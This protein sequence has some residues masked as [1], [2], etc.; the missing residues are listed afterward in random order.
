MAAGIPAEI[1]AGTTWLQSRMS[2]RC[3]TCW[4]SPPRRLAAQSS[5]RLICGRVYH[6]IP[7]NPEDM[8]KTAITSCLDPI[9]LIFY[10]ERASQPARSKR[11]RNERRAE[12]R[13]E[14]C[15]CDLLIKANP[16]PPPHS[17]P[18]AILARPVPLP[19]LSHCSAR[20]MTSSLTIPAPF[21]A[22]SQWPCPRSPR[23]TCLKEETK[24]NNFL[25]YGFLIGVLG[26]EQSA[27]KDR[28]KFSNYTRPPKI[29]RSA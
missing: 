16:P 20:P 8:Q 26:A 28:Q 24:L 14:S 12:S 22:T 29:L 21:G 7:V 5:P 17:S 3:P 4:T 9:D 1:S 15:S 13:R 27:P 19:P 6:Q 11:K 10:R 18:G 2:T 25:L 23:G